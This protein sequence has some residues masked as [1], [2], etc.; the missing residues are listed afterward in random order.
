[1]NVVNFAL[2][3]CGRISEKHIDALSKIKRARII[4]V[5]DKDTALSEKISKKIKANFFKS[6][7]DLFNNSYSDCFVITSPNGL[8]KSQSIKALKKGFDV[9]VE[10]PMALNY[11]DVLK[12]YETSA[13]FKRKLYPVF[14]LRHA[15][16][17]TRVKSAIERKKLGKILFFSINQ[18]ITRPQN[19]FDESKW[20]GTEIMD[21]GTLLNQ[22]IHYIDLVDWFFGSVNK[23]NSFSKRLSRDIETEDSSVINFEMV[24]GA[25]GSMSFTVLASPSNLETSLT[26]VGEKGTIKLEGSSLEKIIRWSTGNTKN[27]E[28]ND[29]ENEMKSDHQTFYEEMIKNY[30]GEKSHIDD[31]LSYRA[32]AIIDAIYKS[33]KRNSVVKVNY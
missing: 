15:K 4:E 12:M 10:K 31:S 16:T 5:F 33:A 2:V 22:A 26:I 14:Q 20:R 23:V 3:G 13:E 11:R 21:G 24:N 17:I 1:M 27:I 18:I 6:E 28:T 7:N 32:N 9:I 30:C 25:I 19:Y 29:N 8:H